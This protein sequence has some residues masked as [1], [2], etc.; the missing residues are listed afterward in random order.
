MYG[1]QVKFK[2]RKPVTIQVFCLASGLSCGQCGSVTLTSLAAAGGA[3]PAAATVRGPG[4][5]TEYDFR[6]SRFPPPEYSD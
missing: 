4:P 2:C 3:T 1:T 6:A 5:G